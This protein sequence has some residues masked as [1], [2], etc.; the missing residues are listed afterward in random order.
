MNVR[1]V[2]AVG[3]TALVF[4]C[5]EEAAAPLPAP[6]PLPAVDEGP[7]SPHTAGAECESC[8]TN[9]VREWRISPHA[10]AINDPVFHAMVRLGQAETEGDLGQFCTQCHSPLGVLRGETSVRFDADAG[11]FRQETQELS[12]PAMRGVSCD[13]CHSITSVEGRFNA[14]FTTA[15]DGVRRAPIQFPVPTAAHASAY[16]PLHSDSLLCGSCHNLVSERFSNRVMLE[17]TAAE[18]VQSGFN[19]LT[20]CQDCHMPEYRGSAAPGAPERA[21]HRH[22]F[23][24]VDVPLVEENA[25]PG[26]HEMRE[27]TRELLERS[28]ELELEAVPG[29]RRV[30]VR[31]ANL[32]GHS[33]PSGAAADREAWIELLVKDPAGNLVFESGTLDA[34]GD[35]RVADPHRTIAPGT[36]PQLTLYTQHMFFDP[37][38]ETPPGV[39]PRILVDFLWQANSHES[40]L[41]VAGAGDTRSYDLSALASGSYVAEAR[42]RFRSFPPHMLRRLER[43]AGLDPNVKTRVPIVDMETRSLPVVLP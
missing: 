38:L 22:Y 37:S 23:V 27:L 13:V 10:Y 26:Y 31:I 21:L 30:I 41:L 9:H 11:V 42:L 29:E 34:N 40:K 6:S 5:G 3:L 14:S 20:D 17:R 28:A 4:G 35:L 2:R 19:G 1:L 18:W 8:H 15:L 39:S 33:I 43:E 24:G 36:D 32:A 7:Y 12:G 16:S 25:F